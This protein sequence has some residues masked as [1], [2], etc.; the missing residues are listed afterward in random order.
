MLTQ[1]NNL[2]LAK[3]IADHAHSK[4]LAIAQKN[5][6]ELGS[7]GKTTAGFDFAVAEECQKEEECQEYID[8]YGDLVLEIEYTDNDGA[9]AIYSA[10]CSDHG[11]RIAVIHRD[12]DLVPSGQ[13]GYHYEAC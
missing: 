9:A 7:L 13:S 6:A 3:L 11:S 4:N 2:A 10:A 8:A 12:R 1:A 5:V